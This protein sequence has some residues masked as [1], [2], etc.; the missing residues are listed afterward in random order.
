[1]PT[2]PKSP[3]DEPD[4]STIAGRMRHARLLRGYGLKSLALDAG[5]SSAA[6]DHIEKHPAGDVRVGSLLAI[7]RKLDVNPCW[8]AF[9]LGE[10][11]PFP[12]AL[13]SVVEA[14]LR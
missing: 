5:L 3:P 14:S 12:R 1:M 4:L 10:M 9:H 6:V 2:R 7:A 8:L 11:E 13:L